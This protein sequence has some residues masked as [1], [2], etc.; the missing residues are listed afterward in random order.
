MNAEKILQL[1]ID[2][3]HV[4][5]DLIESLEG[6]PD[7]ATVMVVDALH[8]LLCKYP[9]NNIDT[10]VDCVWCNYYNLNDWTQG[11]RNKWLNATIKIKKKLDLS[12]AMV[13]KLV[14]HLA[15]ILSM[16]EDERERVLLDLVYEKNP[17]EAIDSLDSA[18]AS[19]E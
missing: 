13:L 12:N 11:D 18:Q 17:L 8:G 3:G 10:D 15:R 2:H 19:L 4:T 5:E 16:I 9:H 7:N 1:L 6:S 14:G